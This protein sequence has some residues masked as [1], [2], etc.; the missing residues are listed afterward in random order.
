MTIEANRKMCFLT[1]VLIVVRSLIRSLSHLWVEA[2]RILDPPPQ[3]GNPATSLERSV[4]FAP[5]PFDRLAIIVATSF[6]ATSSI[7]LQ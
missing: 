2:E 4:G 1:K 6:V 5:L 3:F 7:L